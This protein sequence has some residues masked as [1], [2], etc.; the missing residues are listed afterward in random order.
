[1]KGEENTG[2]NDF[3]KTKGLLGSSLVG[4]PGNPD[5]ICT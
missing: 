4:L 5:R 3:S 1:M 2:Q